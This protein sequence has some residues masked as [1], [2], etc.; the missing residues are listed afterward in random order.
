MKVLLFGA[1]GQV[2][3]ALR[4]NLFGHSELLAISR[5]SRDYGELAN[6]DGISHIIRSFSPQIIINA[7]A[8]TSVQEAE[9]EKD[10][11]E[12][13]NILA[14]AT[15]AKIAKQIDALFVHYSSDYVFDGTKGTPYTEDDAQFPLNIYGQSKLESERRI[16]ATNCY[17][18]IL[19]SSW[20][21]DAQ[22]SNFLTFILRKINAGE[23]INIRANQIGSP[24]SARF[25]ASCTWKMIKNYRKKLSGIYH[26]TCTGSTTWVGYAQLIADSVRRMST[27][28]VAQTSFVKL[29]KTVESEQPPRPHYCVLDNSK[30]QRTFGIVGPAWDHE[31]VEH[32]NSIQKYPRV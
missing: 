23:D 7:A 10:T 30:L 13:I 12:K 4:E 1:N 27:E 25:L 8:F 15:M 32:I 31:I 2:G 20:I 28:K 9:H 3:T 5:E 24:T 21:Y 11:V 19:R 26:T 18:L 17:H 6:L 16:S 29:S 22:H 14:P